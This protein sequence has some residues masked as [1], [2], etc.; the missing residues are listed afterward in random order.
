MTSVGWTVVALVSVLHLTSAQVEV[1]PKEEIPPYYV[2]A[3]SF[4]SSTS[5]HSRVDVFVQIPYRILA[6]VK[7]EDGYR[8]SYEITIDVLDSTGKLCNEKVWTEDVKVET[9]EQTV[10]SQGYSLVQRSFEVFPGLYSIMTIVRD[11]ETRQSQRILQKLRVSDYSGSQLLLSDI[12]L[13]NRLNLSGER[14]SIVPNVSPNVGLI[15]DAFH[16]FF[17]AYNE[18][19]LDSVKFVIDILDQK[20]ERTAQIEQVQKLSPGRNQVFMRIENESLSVGDYT[21][22]VRA[23]APVQPEGQENQSLAVTS[24]SFIVRWKGL[25]AAVKDIDIAIEQCVYEAK[26]S[27]MSHMREANTPEEKQKRFLEFWKKRDPNP[28]TPRNEK[29]ESYF[30]RVEYANKTFKHYIEGWRTD[31]GMVYIIF[32]P[33]NNVERHPFDIDSKPYEVW[34]YYTLNHSFEFVDNS[35]FGDYRLTTPIWEVWER[36]H[37]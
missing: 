1:A 7:K 14:K 5:Q 25:P 36:P 29:M 18:P 12:M 8:A 35:G 22:L 23:F 21:L 32:G 28:S 16:I 37:D 4:A 19:K 15:P 26:S 11:E 17:E 10:S 34:T 33:P 24:R 2:D 9:F 3:I 27:E 20:K 13:V 31:M 30:A 6:F